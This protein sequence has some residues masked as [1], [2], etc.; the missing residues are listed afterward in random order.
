MLSRCNAVVI[1][2]AITIGVPLPAPPPLL[3]PPTPAAGP[4]LISLSLQF[5]SADTH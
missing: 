5:L 3:P 4:A 1:N 2:F